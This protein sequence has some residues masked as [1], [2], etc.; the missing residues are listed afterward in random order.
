M[1][2]PFKVTVIGGGLAGCEAALQLAARKVHV[3]LIEAKPIWKSGAHETNLFAEVV[4]SNSFKSVLPTTASGMLKNELKILG[5]KLMEIAQEVSL[6][7]GSALA[8]DREKFA[9]R[10]TQEVSNNSYIEIKHTLADDFDPNSPTIIAAGPLC[11]DALAERLAHYLG[12]FLH[13]YDAVSP[14]VTAESIDFSRAFYGSRYGKGGDDYV[15]CPMTKAE[16]DAFYNALINAE[17]VV[18]RDFEHEIFEGCMPVEV[19]AKRGEKALLFGTMRPVGFRVD[20]IRPYA[21]LQLRRENQS[22]T[23]LNLVGFQ[24]NLK[25]GE[26]KKVFSMIPALKNAE[27][28]RFG[29]MHRNSFVSAP[30]YLTNTLCTKKYKNLFI[31]G[32]LCGVEGYVES[33]AAGLYGAINLYRSLTDKPPLVLPNTTILG[34]LA[35][36]LTTPNPNFQPMNSNFGILPPLDNPPRDK[37]ER[38]QAYYDRGQKDILNYLSIE[39]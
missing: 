8:V 6:P 30:E 3:T 22:G 33:I 4:C 12:G 29:V 28:V 13:F 7:A 16:Y 32:Q 36:Y 37:S 23:L 2:Y 11:H 15:N 14:I 27:F 35:E 17:T 25:I 31:V 34:A 24:T 38:K 18:L 39:K 10:V 21:V 20:G 19:M 5:C 1:T 9:E 26:Q